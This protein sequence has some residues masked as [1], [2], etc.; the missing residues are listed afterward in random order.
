MEMDGDS[1]ETDSVQEVQN[2]KPEFEGSQKI[3]DTDSVRDIPSNENLTNKV[4]ERNHY[5]CGSFQ[6]FECQAIFRTFFDLFTHIVGY[7]QATRSDLLNYCNNCGTGFRDG[8]NYQTHITRRKY[9]LPEMPFECDNCGMGF[10]TKVLLDF[11]MEGHRNP[12]LIHCGSCDKTFS[13][14]PV[15]FVK[16]Y[17][18]HLPNINQGN[19]KEKPKL[20]SREPVFNCSLCNEVFLTPSELYIHL[21]THSGFETRICLHCGLGFDKQHLYNKHK[22]KHKS[23]PDELSHSCTICK[24]QFQNSTLLEVHLQVHNGSYLYNCH[25]CS[26]DFKSGVGLYYHLN[27]PIEKCE[28]LTEDHKISPPKTLF[29]N[30]KAVSD[31]RN[32]RKC[33]G[34][35]LSCLDFGV[36]KE[37]TK[38]GISINHKIYKYKS[39]IYRCFSCQE[40]FGK[41]EKLYLHLKE[42][43]FD[44]V[45][46]CGMCGLGVSG[47]ARFYKHKLSHQTEKLEFLYHCNVCNSKFLCLDMLDKHIGITHKERGLLR[48]DQC[49]DSF[50]SK[51]FKKHL[52]TVVH[53]KNKKK[54]PRNTHDF[55]DKVNTPP[56]KYTPLECKHC[57]RKCRGQMELNMHINDKHFLVC[58]LCNKKFDTHSEMKTHN[59]VDHAEDFPFKCGVCDNVFCDYKT[60]IHH[61]NIHSK[62]ADDTVVH[63]CTVCSRM[64]TDKQQ[65]ELHQSDHGF[66]YCTNCRQ[67]LDSGID[68]KKHLKTCPGAARQ[69]YKTLTQKNKG[70]IM[71]ENMIIVE[72]FFEKEE[73][74]DNER[75]KTMV[76]DKDM[77]DMNCDESQENESEERLMNKEK[78][79]A[80]R[81]RQYIFKRPLKKKE[82]VSADGRN[83]FAMF[84][85]GASE[86][87]IENGEKEECKSNSSESEINNSEK[88]KLQVASE[89]SDSLVSKS[90]D[91]RK[92]RSNFVRKDEKSSTSNMS[93]MVVISKHEENTE[94]HIE[95]IKENDE[96]KKTNNKIVATGSENMSKVDTNKKSQTAC[97]R[98]ILPVIKDGKIE[99]FLRFDPMKKSHDISDRLS[100][101][102]VPISVK[103]DQ[104]RLSAAF[105]H[106]IHIPNAN[107]L[108]GQKL[109]TQIQ[110][111]SKTS[112]AQTLIQNAGVLNK[113][114]LSSLTANSKLS[115]LK[116]PILLPIMNQGNIQSVLSYCPFKTGI[117]DMETEATTSAL[118][119][120]CTEQ[121]KRSTN[122]VTSTSSTIYTNQTTIASP[123][124]FVITDQLTK[125]IK[126]V[127]SA[128]EAVGTN[129]Q[130]ES[131]ESADRKTGF[132]KTKAGDKSEKSSNQNKDQAGF[133]CIDDLKELNRNPVIES[134]KNILEANNTS[135]NTSKSSFSSKL[136]EKSETESIELD[137][138]NDLETSDGKQQCR[139][140]RTRKQNKKYT[141]GFVTGEKKKI[142]YNTVKFNWNSNLDS[143]RQKEI[144]VHSSNQK[145][146]RKDSEESCSSTYTESI[147]EKELESSNPDT[148]SNGNHT[149]N[150]TDITMKTKSDEDTT[151]SGKI[152]KNKQAYSW[153][154]TK[155][156]YKKKKGKPHKVK[157]NKKERHLLRHKGEFT[158]AHRND[159]KLDSANATKKD[160]GTDQ[161]LFVCGHCKIGFENYRYLIV[162]LPCKHSGQ[163]VF[164]CFQCGLGYIYNTRSSKEEINRHKEAH[165]TEDQEM[166]PFICPRYKCSPNAFKSKKLKEIHK[167]ICHDKKSKGYL[168]CDICNKYK[169]KSTIPRFITHYKR[170]LKM[171]FIDKQNK[172]DKS[173][174]DKQELYSEEKSDDDI[175]VR[176]GNDLDEQ[177]VKEGL[178]LEESSANNDLK[179][180][181]GFD[182]QSIDNVGVKQG[183]NL[184]EEQSSII[185]RRRSS[186]N[187][188]SNAK[189]VE[190]PSIQSK[191]SKNNIDKNVRLSESSKPKNDKN[192]D[193]L[194]PDFKE[195]FSTADFYS[196]GMD[197]DESDIGD[198]DGIYCCDLCT[199]KFN[200][201][202]D[203]YFHL[204]EHKLSDVKYVWP[205]IC[206]VCGRGTKMSTYYKGRLSSPWYEPHKKHEHLQLLYTCQICN[207]KFNRQEFLDLH[208]RKHFGQELLVCTCGKDFPNGG[209]FVIHIKSKICVMPNNTGVN[210]SD[211]LAKET[212][213]QEYDSSNT[214]PLTL[215]TELPL[216][217][218]RERNDAYINEK[219]NKAKDEVL[220]PDKEGIDVSH[221]NAKNKLQ[222]SKKQKQLSKEERKKS[223]VLKREMQKKRFKLLQKKFVDAR[224]KHKKTIKELNGVHCKVC[225]HFFKFDKSSYWAGYMCEH[226]RSF[227]YTNAAVCNQCGKIFKQ[228]HCLKVHI[229]RM[230]SERLRKCYICN[231]PF[232]IEIALHQ[233]LLK[234]HNVRHTNEMTNASSLMEDHNYTKVE[235]NVQK[236][237]QNIKYIDVTSTD[238]VEGS[239]AE[240]YI[241]K[242]GDKRC[243]CKLC[244]KVIN[245]LKD[246]RKHVNRHLTEKNITCPICFRTFAFQK[247]LDFHKKDTHDSAKRTCE[248]C[249]KVLTRRGYQMHIERLHKDVYVREKKIKCAI[250]QMSFAYFKD[251]LHHRKVYHGNKYKCNICGQ[252]FTE[253][254]SH[255]RHKEKKH[256]IIVPLDTRYIARK[257]KTSELSHTNKE[258][259]NRSKIIGSKH[260]KG[261]QSKKQIR[262]TLDAVSFLQS[263]MN[264]S[265]GKEPIIEPSTN[266]PSL[267]CKDT[268]TQLSRRIQSKSAGQNQISKI[269]AV[270][271]MKNVQSQNKSLG[272]NQT[273]SDVTP[274][275]SS[276]SNIN[277]V[278]T[279]TVTSDIN[280]S[281]QP[282]K[283]KHVQRYDHETDEVLLSSH[284]GGGANLQEL[285]GDQDRMTVTGENTIIAN[286]L[287]KVN[288]VTSDE[289]FICDLCGAILPDKTNLNA[290]HKRVHKKDT[291]QYRCNFCGVIV[292]N[293]DKASKHKRKFHKTIKYVSFCFTPVIDSTKQEIKLDIDVIPDM[294]HSLEV[295]NIRK[296]KQTHTVD[297]ASKFIKMANPL[298]M[299]VEQ[300]GNQENLL[301]IQDKVGGHPENPLDIEDEQDGHQEHSY[302]EDDESDFEGDDIY[303]ENI[304]ENDIINNSKESTLDK[305]IAPSTMQISDWVQSLK[306]GQLTDTVP[307]VLIEE[308]IVHDHDYTERKI[309]DEMQENQFIY[310][311]TRLDHLEDVEGK[312][313]QKTVKKESSIF[314]TEKSVPNF[315]YDIKFHMI[316]SETPY[317]ES[318]Y[319]NDK[320]DKVRNNRLN[321]DQSNRID[322]IQS[323]RIDTVQSNR[324]D[325][326]EIKREVDEINVG[327]TPSK[328]DKQIRKKIVS[329]P[330]I[331]LDKKNSIGTDGVMEGISMNN[332]N[333]QKECY[334]KFGKNKLI[335]QTVI[336]TENNENKNINRVV[337]VPQKLTKPYAANIRIPDYYGPIYNTVVNLPEGI[338][339]V[340]LRVVNMDKDDQDIYLF[341]TV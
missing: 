7:H 116:S 122:P 196:F 51:D 38:E 98:V 110:T 183:V 253:S 93:D 107:D 64:F 244:G 27:D 39:E 37:T 283:S 1:I 164:I 42:H 309:L 222:I 279:C 271:M 281:I 175:L 145:A 227:T 250:C 100:L 74:L 121:S 294:H 18:H 181:P 229:K 72:G 130:S 318:K 156:K 111:P 112:E 21:K 238:I 322:T 46:I 287:T 328:I 207:E 99:S 255:R 10:T 278:K 77:K 216:L 2:S 178:F 76:I 226:S 276:H 95:S 228:K 131:A 15:E 159:Q 241:M 160:L 295:N 282:T 45:D 5:Q 169:V 113:S 306:D 96:L 4:C 44:K 263:L 190:R 140:L 144:Q 109:S 240:D 161:S 291:R 203:L 194:K 319:Q 82:S 6:C 92:T 133:Q 201:Y 173:E 86:I 332:E 85:S 158:T 35:V 53:K 31:D 101:S 284:R 219:K 275:Q 290:H 235:K 115:E 268:I 20:I 57:D 289:F 300:D 170:C 186:R 126:S 339:D 138:D 79:E 102:N 214:Q 310:T 274:A 292:E 273:A 225:N 151:H 108:I 117:I 233:H 56:G 83:L 305:V 89:K 317:K 23:N 174:V 258:E 200:S 124:A 195:L 71:D 247:D 157:L 62:L 81:G 243:A 234:I 55:G 316:E 236:A 147:V 63:V 60:M 184:Q 269:P 248:F 260:M 88:Q 304:L 237:P 61:I 326:V 212:N 257:S 202:S 266:K 198:K 66:K 171:K 165:K 41:F 277:S 338:D 270:P 307:N 324:I 132:M 180:L 24:E 333:Q 267:S 185:D 139:S 177:P 329:K 19:E 141:T 208:M 314:D 163:D 187:K 302:T 176:Q 334:F 223:L 120:N 135:R 36:N 69:R 142:I 298:V 213:E 336:D 26:K 331:I 49:N 148:I 106:G 94:I 162:H 97:S 52:Y 149:D 220:V 209:S 166:L 58:Q 25:M 285:N 13:V 259:I 47:T 204:H 252:T 249:G 312:S 232:S 119:T 335:T 206:L 67:R 327:Q 297:G 215:S 137:L 40:S 114:S 323:N 129:Q 231:T 286:S 239:K 299:E 321:L 9:I 341:F 218:A 261:N 105:S 256:G 3:P 179:Q 221:V 11:H 325:T 293:I 337:N 251:M 17:R 242:M 340:N 30:K 211:T 134:D 189:F 288:E 264:S 172:E 65:Y 188:K 87:N 73:K 254:R 90:A 118:S 91:K 150:E 155:T 311:A 70:D 320:E 197:I 308:I 143:L 136:S 29:K 154:Y 68:L 34:S 210:L 50:S 123:S 246:C 192:T 230:H 12:D 199:A 32:D 80:P 296:R 168:N 315:K 153:S 84:T 59:K 330:V 280:T 313:L 152:K 167:Q 182:E 103:V 125:P 262:E 16:H 191:E 14:N 22:H 224:K 104:L 193:S 146:V 265:P 33:S 205:V 75:N 43:G 128:T 127:Y 303:K 217:S 54:R 78:E 245:R 301:G 28:M 48:C 8:N 272:P